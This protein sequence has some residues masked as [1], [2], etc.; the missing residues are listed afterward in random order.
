MEEW[1][2]GDRDVRFVAAHSLEEA[3]EVYSRAFQRTHIARAQKLLMDSKNT[4]HGSYH[5][6]LVRSVGWFDMDGGR[7]NTGPS[8][9][10][11]RPPRAQEPQTPMAQ[12]M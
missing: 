8:R 5:Y 7:S 9:Q 1:K 2:I 10:T 6:G 3:L 11:R 4:R 12:R